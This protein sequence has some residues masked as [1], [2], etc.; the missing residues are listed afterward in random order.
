MI[1]GFYEINH[2]NNQVELITKG[3]KVIESKKKM[4]T[5]KL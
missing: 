3:K 1:R 2:V 5:E 4:Y